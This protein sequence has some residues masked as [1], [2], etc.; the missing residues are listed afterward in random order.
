MS[1]RIFRTVP[2][3]LLMTTALAWN[4]PA[5]AQATAG[6]PTGATTGTMQKAPAPTTLPPPAPE[7][8]PRGGTAPGDGSA[9]PADLTPAMPASA[10][11]GAVTGKPAR[12]TPPRSTK[13]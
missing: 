1:Q 10:A 11:S 2:A 3:A 6:S 8:T 12:S 4:L 7:T 13:P 9:L 5:A